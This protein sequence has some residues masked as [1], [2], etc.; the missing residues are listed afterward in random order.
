M[1]EIM[2]GP[3]VALGAAR[4]SLGITCREIA[5]ALNLSQHV[6]EAIEANDYENL[7][8]AVFTRGYIRAYARLLELDPD[9]FVAQFA[10]HDDD[11]SAGEEISRNS[12]REFIREHPQWVLGGSA[13]VILLLLGLVL[14]WSMTAFFQTD[15]MKPAEQAIIV[16]PT[17]AAEQVAGNR[18]NNEQTPLPE[19][20]AGA[21]NGGVRAGT[22]TR[23]PETAAD[24]SVLPLGASVR[25]ISAQGND[26]LWFAFSDECWVEVLS[27]SGENL[28]SELSR[29]GQTLELVGS[30]PFRILLGYAPGVRMAFNGEPVV[31]GPHTRN[32]VANLVLGQ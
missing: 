24:L 9:P 4:D 5:E 30:G 22:E 26:H 8:A 3:G 21:Q 18:E 19:P 29:S 12:T 10:A 15:D 23:S 16:A 20:L 31:L 28:Y 17:G 13:V 2:E 6:V 7:P 27:T 11:D 1:S 25:R 32:N 14:L